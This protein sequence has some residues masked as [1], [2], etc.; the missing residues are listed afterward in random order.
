MLTIDTASIIIEP[1]DLSN[2]LSYGSSVIITG[3]IS[4]DSSATIQLWE[5][6]DSA[7]GLINESTAAYNTNAITYVAAA[8]G[9]ASGYIR[10]HWN[11]HTKDLKVAIGNGGG[12]AGGTKRLIY[13]DEGLGPDVLK[14]EINRN[15]FGYW[16]G[17]GGSAS[18]EEVYGGTQSDSATSQSIGYNGLGWAGWFMMFAEGSQTNLIPQDLSMYSKLVVYMKT[19]TADGKVAIECKNTNNA[20]IRKFTGTDDWPALTSDWQRYEMDITSI[21][22]VPIAIPINIVFE[23]LRNMPPETIYIDNIYFE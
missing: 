3:R 11:G 9:S 19:D 22:S 13:N 7:L 17:G 6:S 15:N 18:M 12:D 10:A 20:A 14:N 8:N 23:A 5:I 21:N 1:A 2:G 4:T 16:Y